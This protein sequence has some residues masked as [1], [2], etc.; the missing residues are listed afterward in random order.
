MQR[1]QIHPNPKNPQIA[2]EGEALQQAGDAKAKGG[3]KALENKERNAEG[4]WAKDA[5]CS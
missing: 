4:L 3:H 1:L 2:T 5:V